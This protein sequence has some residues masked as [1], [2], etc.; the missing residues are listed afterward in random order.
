MDLNIKKENGEVRYDRIWAYIQ[1]VVAKI[2]KVFEEEANTDL[3][4]TKKVKDFKRYPGGYRCKITYR[5]HL[6]TEELVY[7]LVASESETFVMHAK[8]IFGPADTG[9]ACPIRTTIADL[10]NTNP[11]NVYPDMIGAAQA[12]NMSDC[13][14]FNTAE[15]VAP[16]IEFVRGWLQNAK[17][18][19]RWARLVNEKAAAELMAYRKESEELEHLLSVNR[20]RRESLAN[21]L[22]NL[23]K[24]LP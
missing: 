22:N 10:L 24:V 11:R 15:K 3:V 2:D 14:V 9:Y 1:D 16:K 18:W 20:A 19:M 8:I 6:G 7:R 4:Y 5:F 13:S 23:M 21:K 12:F 17:R